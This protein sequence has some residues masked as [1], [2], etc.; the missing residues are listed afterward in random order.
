M[1]TKTSTNGSQE[2]VQLSDTEL[3]IL[4][5][6]VL[7]C[8]RPQ[9]IETQKVDPDL[10]R[11]FA[12][13]SRAAVRRAEPHG[14]NGENGENGDNG[15]NADNAVGASARRRESRGGGQGTA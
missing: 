2:R 7:L 13:L 4:C 9:V 5:R 3:L 14:E 11:L 12:K 15:D 6:L 1:N 8:L 10:A